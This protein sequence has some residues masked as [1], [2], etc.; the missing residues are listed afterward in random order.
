MGHASDDADDGGNRQPTVASSA[1]CLFV[2]A[3][4]RGVL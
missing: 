2:I 4:Y 3:A 1:V